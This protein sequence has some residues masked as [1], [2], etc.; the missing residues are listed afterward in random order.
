MKKRVAV[1]VPL[2]SH[3]Q[4]SPDE[5]ISLRHLRHYLGQY[6]RFVIAPASMDVPHDDFQVVRFGDEYFGSANA[7]TRL[8][9]RPEYYEA[10]SDYEYILTYQ[11][12]AL[13]LSDRL[14]EWCDEGF[15]FIGPPNYGLKDHLNE[16]YSGG[17]S[18]RKVDSFLAVLRSKRYAVEPEEY[19]RR[20]TADM[21][22]LRKACNL[23]RRYLKRL[24]AFNNVRREIAM[25]MQDEVML[26]DVF[27]QERA[28]QYAPGFR[29]P[30]LERALRFAF[31]ETPRIAYRQA[32]EQ[33]PFGAHAWY[34]QDRAF[35]E[36]FLLI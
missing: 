12:D 18:L 4:L 21:G 34:K 13:V 14:L 16:T 33:L 20:L 5:E 35:W 32:G 17:F 36:P 1:T 25:Q 10:F 11:L 8:M 15:D 29:L 9:F 6:D 28:R 23:P 26:E 24:H 30:P 2:N 22:L 19:W 7:Q 31:D 27:F 3:P